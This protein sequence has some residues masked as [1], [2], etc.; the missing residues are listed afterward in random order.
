MKCGNHSRGARYVDDIFAIGQKERCDRLCVDLNQTIPVKNLG[1]LKWY[2][3]GC[4]KSEN[5]F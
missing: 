4:H 5:L 2:E 1:D 3:Q